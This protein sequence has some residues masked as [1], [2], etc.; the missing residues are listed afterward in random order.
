MSPGPQARTD[1]R[2]IISSHIVTPRT[3]ITAIIGCALFVTAVALTRSPSARS[4][5]TRRGDHFGDRPDVVLPIIIQV[6][7]GHLA[8]GQSCGSSPTRLAVLSVTVCSKPAPVVCVAQFGVTLVYAAVLLGVVLPVPQARRQ[9][10]NVS[11]SGAATDLWPA[12]LT[13]RGRPPTQ[14]AENFAAR[15]RLPATGGCTHML[16][17]CSVIVAERRAQR[18]QAAAG[19]PPK[20]GPFQRPPVR[21][22][23]GGSRSE[24]RGTAGVGGR[25]RSP[26]AAGASSERRRPGLA[27][28]PGSHH[29]QP[30]QGEIPAVGEPVSSGGVGRG[31]DA[32]GRTCWRRLAGRAVRALCSSWVTSTVAF[33]RRSRTTRSRPAPAA[34]APAVADRPVAA[35]KPGQHSLHPRGGSIEDILGLCAE[36]VQ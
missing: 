20:A 16:Q 21:N 5:G 30:G 14:I 10:T 6:L 9:T 31:A 4:S 36:S 15:A 32:I 23:A 18:R 28:R 12:P 35:D 13:L 29:H 27:E 26:A 3:V 19:C 24:S 7:P 34:S 8:R 17:F 22:P 11:L 2:T 25:R 1:R 33:R